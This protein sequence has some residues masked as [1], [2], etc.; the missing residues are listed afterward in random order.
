MGSLHRRALFIIRCKA[1]YRDWNNIDVLE[2]NTGLL[3]AIRSLKQ[4]VIIPAIVIQV[5]DFFLQE[6]ANFKVVASCSFS[7]NKNKKFNLLEDVWC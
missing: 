3:K 1:P 4:T 5:R 7:Q 6:Y 2:V